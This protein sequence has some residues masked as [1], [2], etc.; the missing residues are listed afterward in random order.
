MS[1]QPGK[2]NRI[3]KTKDLSSPKEIK[4]MEI[5]EICNN[6]YLGTQKD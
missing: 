2:K 3:K 4:S 5:R 1:K 6:A